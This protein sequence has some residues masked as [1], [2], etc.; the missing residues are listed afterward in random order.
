MINDALEQSP[1]PARIDL[2]EIDES[3]E[4][5]DESTAENFHSI[6]ALLLFVA[7]CARPDIL[8]TISFLCT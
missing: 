2:F 4:R 3:S 5:L 6:I 7:F 1:T 8:L